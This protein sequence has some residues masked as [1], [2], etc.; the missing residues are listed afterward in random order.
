MPLQHIVTSLY[1]L[2]SGV[3][4]PAG[5]PKIREGTPQGMMFTVLV[6]GTTGAGEGNP[7]PAAARAAPLPACKRES[8]EMS[9]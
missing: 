8:K 4:K 9:E 1:V 7:T 5:W 2:L 3:S 6:H